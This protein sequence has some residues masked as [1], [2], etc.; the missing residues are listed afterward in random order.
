MATVEYQPGDYR[1]LVT[2]QGWQRAATGS[3]MLVLRIQ[4]E[5]RAAV[6]DGKRVADP[7]TGGHRTVRLVVA[8]EKQ[9]GMVLKKLRHAGFEGTKW[10]EVDLLDRHVYAVCRHEP[11][12]GEPSEEWDL[13]LPGAGPLT[14]DPKIVAELDREYPIAAGAYETGG[15]ADE[16]DDIPF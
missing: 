15:I 10:S 14:D 12:Q 1:C 8:G 7:V 3:K 5:V 9:A 2:E 4:P 16:D 11:Y 6:R 13:M